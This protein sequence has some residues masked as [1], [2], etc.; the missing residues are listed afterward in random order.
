MKNMLTFGLLG[1]LMSGLVFAKENPNRVDLCKVEAQDLERGRI[2]EVA[3]Y[4]LKKG[5]KNGVYQPVIKISLRTGKNVDMPGSFFKN[6]AEQKIYKAKKEGQNEV[7]IWQA[8]SHQA[9]KAKAVVTLKDGKP[10]KIKVTLHA[11]GQD[12]PKSSECA[13]PWN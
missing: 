9:H 7:I 6:E 4:M 3:A 8:G 13:Y 10:D 11:P 5:Y 12:S 2:M 1:L